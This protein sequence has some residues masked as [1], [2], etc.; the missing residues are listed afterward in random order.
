LILPSLLKSTR[1]QH[2]LCWAERNRA[3]RHGGYLG[4]DR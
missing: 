4:K 2:Q 3:L 1:R